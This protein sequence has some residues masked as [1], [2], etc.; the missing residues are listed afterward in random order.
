MILF[1][2]FQMYRELEIQNLKPV[3]AVTCGEQTDLLSFVSESVRMI[4]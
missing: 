2:F 4:E 1:D 3:L